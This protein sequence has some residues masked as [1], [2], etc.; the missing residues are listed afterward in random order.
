MPP[1]ALAFGA[2]V[3]AGV[4]SAVS[5]SASFNASKKAGESADA[6]RKAL[7]DQP[8]LPDQS[9]EEV[10]AARRR[11]VEASGRRQGLRSTILAGKQEEAE[12]LV[13]TQ[14]ILGGS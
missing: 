10:Q 13:R 4:S 3:A 8:T 7:E 2:F 14:T 1:A 9:S 11:G 5:S 6:L 12:T